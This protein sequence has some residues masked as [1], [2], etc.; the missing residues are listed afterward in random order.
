MCKHSWP[1]W[2]QVKIEASFDTVLYWLCFLL[3]KCVT[4]MCVHVHCAMCVVH[5][6]T[7]Q[8]FSGFGE[9]TTN[10]R[11]CV[12]LWN[13]VARL[14][15]KTNLSVDPFIIFFLRCLKTDSA[16]AMNSFVQIRINKIV[17]DVTLSVQSVFMNTFWTRR[18]ICAYA[19]FREDN[20]F[21]KNNDLKM[22]I[23]WID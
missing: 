19:I 22:R 14:L 4:F 17:I 20:L 2:K 18:I 23:L 12:R 6:A 3:W 7:T 16:S 10:E 1:A 9:C 8:T 21:K 11:G 15:F 5:S 13:L